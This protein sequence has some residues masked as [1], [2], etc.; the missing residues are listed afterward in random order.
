[1]TRRS[2]LALLAAAPRDGLADGSPL[3][4]RHPADRDAFRRWFAALAEWVYLVGG[5]Q[6]PGEIT[7]CSA[8]L[9]FCFR[10]SLRKHDGAWARGLGIDPFPALP[11]VRQYQ[12]PRT[13]VGVNLFRT[14]GGDFRQFAD[15]ENLMRYNTVHLSRDVEPAQPGDVLFFRQLTAAEPFHSMVWTGRSLDEASTE[16]YVVYHTGPAGGWKGEV[17]RLTAAELAQHKDS[18][19]RPVPGNAN[20]LGLRRWTLVA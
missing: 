3:R 9:R 18:R 19:W 6:A 4:L 5:R 14:R 12:Y 17:R 20:F 15:A 7:D 13:P 16:S 11:D 2:C 10:E 8:L 1:M